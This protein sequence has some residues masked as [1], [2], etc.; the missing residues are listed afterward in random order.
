MADHGYNNFYTPLEYESYQQYQQYPSED[1]RIS[2]MENTLNIF[3]QQSMINMQDTNQR[4]KNLSFH[5]EMMQEQIMDIQANIQSTHGKQE[6]NSN[7]CEEVGTSVEKGVEDTE[8]DIILEECSTIKMTEELEPLHPIE[9]P[10]ERSYAEEAKTVDN[11]A[12]LIVTEKQEW[13]LSKKESSE[14]K[15]KTTSE[16]KIDRVIDEIC[17]L[18]N[19]PRVGI[20]IS[21]VRNLEIERNF[22]KG[23][24]F[25]HFL[26]N[27]PWRAS[28]FAKASMAPKKP[29]NTGKRKKGET[30]AIRPPARNQAFERERFRSRY[31]QDRYI[32]LLDQ[33]MWCERVFNL[34]PEGPYKEIAKL[35]LDQGW[36]RLLQPITDINAELVPHIINGT[37]L[38]VTNEDI[39]YK[40]T[41]RF[42][43]HDSY[44]I[45]D[46][47]GDP[48]GS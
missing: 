3:M 24:I 46:I 45:L 48:N 19:K 31:H 9:L 10:Q 4:L 26:G 35:L 18:F 38:M 5:M 40:E 25:Y 12:V 43:E 22:E 2:K 42:V 44:T 15:G 20:A 29:T 33:S 30:S 7:T 32:E 37:R 21:R 8:E 47:Q 14:Q 6:N 28:S 41:L 23:S 34:N 36:E 16:A 39:R 17:A 13:I 1:E 11:G 27:S